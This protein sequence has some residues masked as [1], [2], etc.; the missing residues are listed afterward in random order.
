MR[1]VNATPVEEFLNNAAKSWAGTFSGPAYRTAFLQ[2]K[3]AP[4]VDAV[5]V[6][7]CRECENVREENGVF[8]CGKFIGSDV[9]VSTSPDNYCSS[10]RRRENK[11]TEYGE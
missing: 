11:A 4:T 9:K 5:Q 2:V 8:V 10:G 7:R 3:D 6:V 1:L